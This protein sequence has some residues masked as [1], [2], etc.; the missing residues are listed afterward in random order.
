MLVLTVVETKRIKM[1]KKIISIIAT[2]IGLTLALDMSIYQLSGYSFINDFVKFIGFPNGLSSVPFVIKIIVA[3]ILV[4]LIVKYD[5]IFDYS[6]R[7][8]NNK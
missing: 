8:K 4:F 1:Y 3:I 2:L 6:F 7:D 5:Y